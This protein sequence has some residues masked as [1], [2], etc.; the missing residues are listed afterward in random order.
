MGVVTDAC[1]VDG[2]DDAAITS[3]DASALVGKAVW[4]PSLR[5]VTARCSPGD[6]EADTIEHSDEVSEAA[7]EDSVASAAAA[8]CE[9]TSVAVVGISATEPLLCD[10]TSSGIEGLTERDSA[11]L[12]AKLL[13]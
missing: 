2:S 13:L 6:E 5:T 9:T 12:G 11:P 1:C 8:C 10:T 3:D 7:G 4:F